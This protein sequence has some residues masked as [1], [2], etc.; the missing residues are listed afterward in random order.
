MPSAYVLINNEKGYEEVINNL[1]KIE[2]IIEIN[3]IYGI[4]DI[5]I[6]VKASTMKEMKKTIMD[7]RQFNDIKAS[8]TM[9]IVEN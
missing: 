2:N 1:K 3:T 8:L 4:Y 7:I 6:K 5:I 9:I